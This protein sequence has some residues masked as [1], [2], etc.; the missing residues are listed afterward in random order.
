MRFL[1]RAITTGVLVS[2]TAVGLAGSAAADPLSGSYTATVID[3]ATILQ[4]GLTK[5]VMLSP[6][7]QDCTHLSFEGGR[8]QSDLHEDGDDWNGVVPQESEPYRLS[9]DAKTLTLTSV[10]GSFAY[11]WALKENP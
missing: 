10:H 7:G 8:L 6:C 9:L 1:F 2:G 5:Q 11:V 3:G 4:V